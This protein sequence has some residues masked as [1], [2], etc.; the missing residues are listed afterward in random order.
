M[1]LWQAFDVLGDGLI[2]M[3]VGILKLCENY[4]KKVSLFLDFGGFLAKVR[5]SV[6]VKNVCENLLASQLVPKKCAVCE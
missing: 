3:F 5:K 2:T 1:S 4:Q 6:D